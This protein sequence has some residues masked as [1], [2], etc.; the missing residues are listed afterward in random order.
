MEG[1]SG[2]VKRKRKLDN[3]GDICM[4]LACGTNMTFQRNPG[5]EADSLNSIKATGN[6]SGRARLLRFGGALK[7]ENP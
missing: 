7:N 2:D 1:N 6:C 4:L 5:A 3:G